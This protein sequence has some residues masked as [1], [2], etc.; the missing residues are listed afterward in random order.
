M[1]SVT[2]KRDFSYYESC[3]VIFSLNFL[4]KKW[5]LPIL[6]R[7]NEHPVMRYNELLRSMEGITNMMLTQCLKDLQS[8]GLVNRVQYNEMPLRVEYS[9]TPVG[10]D[11][12]PSVYEL[13]LWSVNI[14]TSPNAEALCENSD[15]PAHNM[16]LMN[17]RS[18]E[19]D[20]SINVWDNGD[21]EAEQLLSQCP[22]SMDPMDQV[23]FII[24]HTLKTVATAGEDI[25]R[26][27]T[28]YYLIG[29]NRSEA[30]L[31]EGRAP[32]RILREILT[33]GR[34]S[35]LITDM[36]TNEEIIHSIMA[37][38]HG[39]VAYWELERGSYDIVE[40]N[41]QIIQNYVNGFRKNPR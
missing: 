15:C 35:G 5:I 12:V 33:A 6:C 31:D 21:L 19:L 1:A 4:S 3:P 18:D 23:A 38:R 10:R 40:K 28:I 8:L 11:L 34:A 13:A 9:L 26:L 24:E 2:P 16:Q 20:A 36:L 7:L 41:K 37:F 22:D 17:L 29:E 27:R 14:D 30:F 39:L 32:F 25:S